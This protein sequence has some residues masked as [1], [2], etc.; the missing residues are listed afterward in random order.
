MTTATKTKVSSITVTLPRTDLLDALAAVGRAVPSRAAK[1]V[2]VNVRIGDGLI[3]GTDLEVRIDAAIAEHCE[4]FLVP[5]ARLL[6]IVRA[7]TGDTVTL[8]AG[9][10]SVNV[11][12]GGGKWE[13][14]TEDVAE[15]PAWELANLAAVCRLPADQFHRAAKATTYATDQHSSRYALGAVL[16]EVKDGNPTWVATD[17]RRLACVETETDQAVDDRDVLLPSRVLDIVSGIATGDGSVQIEATTSEVRFEIDGYTVTGRVTD[18]RFPRWRDV[19]GDPEGE[20]SVLEVAELLAATRAAAIVTNE[21]SK[22]IDLVWTSNTLVLSGRSSEYGESTVKCG[23]VA[24]GT[25][26]TT[27]LDPA[28]LADFLRNIP[29]DE[30]PHVDVYVKN[31]QDRVLL[32]CG[33]YTGVI[34]PMA[35]EA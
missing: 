18:G 3:T 19:V 2:L 26:S 28:F 9:G 30:Q 20:A 17:G 34:M 24:A 29:H 16:L 7:C 35:Q 23:V 22:G 10:T 11:K 13:L 33:P 5:H 31:P 32:R 14:P 25:T 6:A 1:P 12:C 27:K 8:K 4:P 21:Q 15:F